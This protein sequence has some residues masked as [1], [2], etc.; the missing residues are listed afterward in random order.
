MYGCLALVINFGVAVY[1][2]KTTE[3]PIGTTKT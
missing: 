2:V 3:N 1:R